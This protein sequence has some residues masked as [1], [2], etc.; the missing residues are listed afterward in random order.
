M[1]SETMKKAILLALALVLI[2]GCA[3][4]RYGRLQPVS[5]TE[6]QLYDCRDIELE[7][8]KVSAFRDQVAKQDDLS[9]ASVAGFLGDFGIGNA[10]EHSAALDTANER[11]KQLRD[12]KSSKG[13]STSS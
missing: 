13:C 7:L 11:E 6:A 9:G 3:T 8:A 4:K 12:L 5:E 10:M 2:G 1:G